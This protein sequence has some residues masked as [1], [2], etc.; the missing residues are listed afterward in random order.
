MECKD[1]DCMG[2]YDFDHIAEYARKR[3]VEG[4]DTLTLMQQASTELE[5]EEIALV[6]LLDVEDD[7][8]RDIRLGC[9]YAE[10]C[11]ITNCRNRLRKMIEM[12]LGRAQAD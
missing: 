4:C 1:P 5:R 10:Q 6:C 3:F 12:E 7:T 9:R 2:E 11:L 8:I